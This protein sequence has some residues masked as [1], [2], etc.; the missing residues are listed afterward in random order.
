MAITPLPEAPA[1]SDTPANFIAKADALVAALPAFVTEAN[2]QAAALT[3]NSTNDTSA[4]SVAI[5]TGAKTFTVSAS[6]SFQ[7]GMYLVIADT[8]A[9]STNSMYGQVTSYSGTTLIMNIISVL[10]SGTKTAWTISQSA[11]GGAGLGGNIFTGLQNFATGANIASAAT[12]N[13]STATG[14]TVHVTGTTPISA[15]TMTSG[16]WMKVIFDAAC[17]LTHHATNHKLSGGASTTLA[18]GDTVYYFYDG[19]T[20]YGFIS[21]ADGTAINRMMRGY[22]AGLTMST[23]GASATM[24]IAVGE[25]ADSVNAALMSLA[26]SINKT[27]SAW[28]VGSGNGGLDTGVI[29]N[30]TGYHFYLIRR[31]DTGVIDV[32][33]STS[34]ASPTLPANYTQYRRI[35]WGKTNG[36]GQW[37][38]FVQVG[39]HFQWDNPVLDIDAVIGATGANSTVSVPS[40]VK[41]I[42]KCNIYGIDGTAGAPG[43]YISDPDIADMAPSLTA[44]PLV[45]MT[46][47]GSTSQ[48]NAN[49]AECFTNT[50]AQIRRRARN[51]TATIRLAT[52]G[53]VD[54]RGGND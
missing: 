15:V 51:S 35:G 8:A 30:N 37:T 28:A 17:P 46:S 21:K 32:I 5:G 42:L 25:A 47:N 9:P 45:Q 50:S 27:T 4:S 34:A 26:A 40:G 3:L 24:T 19:T 53:W 39:N 49:Y 41:V 31:T 33:F 12:I 13:L 48:S 7:P 1:R 14:N 23:A 16:Q 11:A 22:I 18:A 54:F 52:L 43:V 2:A 44:A 38:K 6:K 20:V 36:S 10:G 29:A